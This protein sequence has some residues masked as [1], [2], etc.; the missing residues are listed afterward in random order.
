MLQLFIM[1]IMFIGTCG[2]N[3]TCLTRGYND[4]DNEDIKYLNIVA[5]SFNNTWLFTNWA[6][7]MDTNG[8]LIVEYW[9]DTG[10]ATSSNDIL[11]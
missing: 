6:P 9:C 2:F 7:S 5:Y 11:H 1:V 3:K 10:I 8:T 4:T